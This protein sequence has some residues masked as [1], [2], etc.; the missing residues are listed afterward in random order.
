MTRFTSPAA[1]KQSIEDAFVSRYWELIYTE[2][3]GFPATLLSAL[4]ERL[5]HIDRASWP[6]RFAWGGIFVNGKEASGEMELPFPCRIEYYEPRFDYHDPYS[7]FPR[8]D[9]RW[10][11]HQDDDIICAFKPAK[12]PSLPAREQ[13]R[14]CL[15]VYLEDH[16]GHSVHMPSRLDMST[17]GLLVL[18][19]SARAHN[20]LQRAFETRRVQKYYLL[21]TASAVEFNE[22][23]IDSAIGKDPDHPILRK[24]VSTQ[25]K[26]A[27]THFRVL[28]RGT[29]HGT[30]GDCPSTI[31]LAQPRTGRT[32]QIR[33]HALYNGFPII[34]DTFYGGQPDSE[35][36]LVSAR[37]VLEHPITRKAIDITLPQEFIPRWA[38]GVGF[39]LG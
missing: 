6:E 16:L 3:Q 34:G 10:I 33:V 7:F 24:I 25:G 20:K 19:H 26:P 2:H 28:S 12:L 11:V 5:D 38:Q 18:S 17:S 30:E 15:K 9:P 1:R 4:Q 8:F 37:I 31:L 36:H 14:Y 39:S 35:L 22:K 27:L 13:K 32:H 21:E 23:T 29:F